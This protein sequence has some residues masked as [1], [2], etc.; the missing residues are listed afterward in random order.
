MHAYAVS[1]P[2]PAAAG[3]EEGGDA[4]KLQYTLDALAARDPM[5]NEVAPVLGP[6]LCRQFPLRV[7]VPLLVVLSCSCSWCQA[8]VDQDVLEALQWQAEH[9]AQTVNEY[10]EALVRSFEQAAGEMSKKGMCTEW[11]HG[12]DPGVVGVAGTV[13]GPMLSDLARAVQ[14]Q[15][16]ECVDLFRH[17][18]C[19]RAQ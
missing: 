6:S 5:V 12:C 19:V 4:R 9:D 8:V 16:V 7:F 2:V 17:G 14:H 13:N 1:R 3:D 10:R 11:F 18:A 15:D